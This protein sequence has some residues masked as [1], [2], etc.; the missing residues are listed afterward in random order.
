MKKLAHKFTAHPQETGETYL[1]HLRFTS[2]MSFHLLY[3]GLVIMVHG[4][5]PFL[6][7]RKASTEVIK[8]FHVMKKRIPDEADSNPHFYVI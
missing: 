6:F 1:Q 8:I 4:L 5:F 3:V 7:T 2:K